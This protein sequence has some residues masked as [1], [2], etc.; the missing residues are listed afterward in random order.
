MTQEITAAIEAR[1]S[2]AFALMARSAPALTPERA[3]AEGALALFGE[4]YDEVRVVSMALLMV[5]N[6]RSVELRRYNMFAAPAI[7]GCSRSSAKPWLPPACVDRGAN[8]RRLGSLS[9]A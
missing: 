5:K 3:V 6:G 9:R 7:S 1:S 8:R 4:K 2:P